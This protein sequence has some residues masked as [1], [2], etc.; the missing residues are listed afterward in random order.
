MNFI[1]LSDLHFLITN[2]SSRLDNLPKTQF[3]KLYFIMK[4]AQTYNCKIL[5]AGDFSDIPRSWELVSKLAIF[6]KKYSDIDIFTVFGQHD[7]YLYSELTRDATTLGVLNKTGCLT[8]LDEIPIVVGNVRLFGA[9]FGTK[10]P[11]IKKKIKGIKDVLVIHKSIS[12]KPLF[13]NHQFTDAYS[14]LRKHK[15]Y[16]LILAGDIHRKFKRKI[17]R[18]RIINTGPILRTRNTPYMRKHKPGFYVWNSE[19]NK[20]KWIQIPHDKCE[21]IFLKKPEL[22][23]EGEQFRL[24]K[25]IEDIKE[26]DEY[27]VTGELS[28]I[29]G[30]VYDEFSITEEVQD[31]L[32]ELLS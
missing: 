18:R 32:A 10:V 11:K 12:D 2:P 8:I 15:K 17:K 9:S 14:F 28:T 23:T 29:L 4:F 30:D 13:Y 27:K 26:S 1:L 31:L 3:K 6:F 5:Q 22:S 25:S 7:T 19:T 20:I 21:E 24:I 16:D